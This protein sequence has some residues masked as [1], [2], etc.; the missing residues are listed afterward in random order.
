MLKLF[1][2]YLHKSREEVRLDSDDSESE[3]A[4]E[5]VEKKRFSFGR[6]GEPVSS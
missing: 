1:I 5:S 6:V 2:L 3:L 4:V